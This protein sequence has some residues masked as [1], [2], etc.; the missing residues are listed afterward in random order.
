MSGLLGSRTGTYPVF[1]AL[2]SGDLSGAVP[3][4]G[5]LPASAFEGLELRGSRQLGDDADSVALSIVEFNS[6]RIMVIDAINILDLKIR[7]IL[8][9]PAPTCP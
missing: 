5:T 2:T 6:F 7:E 9:V 3:P 1:Q 4:A 8:N